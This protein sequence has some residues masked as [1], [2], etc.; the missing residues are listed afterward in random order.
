MY[1]K[2]KDIL[3]NIIQLIVLCAFLSPWTFVIANAD[4][5][6]LKVKQVS[7]D[8]KERCEK[9]ETR[10]LN[11]RAHN[12]IKSL[13]SGNEEDKQILKEVAYLNASSKLT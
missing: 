10:V 3:M 7:H 11:K 4:S 13:A 8:W 6:M 12:L 2:R 5:E 1:E 9:T